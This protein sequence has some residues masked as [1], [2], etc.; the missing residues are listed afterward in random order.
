LSDGKIS[1]MLRCHRQAG[2]NP[3]GVKKKYISGESDSTAGVKLCKTGQAK[4][5]RGVLAT[6]GG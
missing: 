6:P 4:V 2:T 5:V 1:V 3:A